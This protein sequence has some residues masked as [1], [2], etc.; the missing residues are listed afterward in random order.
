MSKIDIDNLSIKELEELET[1]IKT[2]L[3]KNQMVNAKVAID[4]NQMY[5]GKCYKKEI[6]NGI[7]YIMVVSA[8]SSN[9]YHLDCMIFESD[10]T[11]ERRLNN[12]MHSS[13]RDAFQPLEYD[14]IRIED[15]PLLCSS[16]LS[17]N[18]VIDEYVPITK[19]EYYEAMDKYILLLKKSLDENKFNDLSSAKHYMEYYQ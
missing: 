9:E 15:L 7:Q 16:N 8:L 11:F 18:K 17:L 1:K 12:S 14:G 4:R 19:Q 10:I 2:K 6:N 13:Y 5:V 3:Q